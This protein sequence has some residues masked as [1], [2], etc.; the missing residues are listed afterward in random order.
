MIILPEP[1]ADP[2]N[3]FITLEL[4]LKRD[5]TVW[6]IAAQPTDLVLTPVQRQRTSTGAWKYVN[7]PARP[8]QR[9]RIISMSASQ[10][11]TL[12]DNG[13]EREIDL[14][15][16]GPW[17]AQIDIG[18]WWRDGEGLFYEVLEMVPHNGYETRALVVKKGHG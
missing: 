6:F 18:D 10:K 8:S 12:T 17:D 14:T 9:L 11:P 1:P 13:I 3:G 15:L 2:P 7:Q 16:L 4:A 5:Q